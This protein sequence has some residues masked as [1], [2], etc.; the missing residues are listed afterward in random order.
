VFG[1]TTVSTGI[2]F[3]NNRIINDGVLP[4]QVAAGTRTPTHRVAIHQMPTGAG[5]GGR[6]ERFGANGNSLSVFRPNAPQAAGTGTRST[7][8]P[9]TPGH[10]SS[11]SMGNASTALHQ[12]GTTLRWGT[13]LILHGA[14]RSAS[15]S[16]VNAS[17]EARKRTPAN[18]LILTGRK[19][20]PQ[21]QSP[22]TLM[23]GADQRQAERSH[24]WA[25]AQV[26][27]AGMY[28]PSSR[29]EGLAKSADNERAQR[30]DRLARSKKLV[31]SDGQYEARSGGDATSS[32]P[33]QPS[34][35]SYQAPRVDY[36]SPRSAPAPRPTYSEAPSFTP[37]AQAAESRPAAISAPARSAPSGGGGGAGQGH[38][39]SGRNRQ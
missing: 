6:V 38:S 30:A 27:S 29:Q 4:S 9:Q 33:W 2:G 10:S 15:Q 31:E 37:R 23:S 14:D 22:A 32:R 18:A 7:A 19:D 35:S 3:S 20:L 26:S 16:G 1:A 8:R 5:G 21:S 28:S 25:P 24:A 39:S 17:A 36:S 13:P 11:G 34:A 12:T